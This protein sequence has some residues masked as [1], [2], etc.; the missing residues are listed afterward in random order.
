VLFQHGG[1]G[2][3][4]GE[5]EGGEVQGEGGGMD[6]GAEA[7]EDLPLGFFASF[8]SGSGWGFEECGSQV[9][10]AWVGR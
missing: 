9:E 8:S 4:R 3:G 10:P 6:G 2:D 5:M 7:E 1:D